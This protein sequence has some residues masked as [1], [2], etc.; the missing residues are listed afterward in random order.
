MLTPHK[1]W[2]VI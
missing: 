1:I 2:W